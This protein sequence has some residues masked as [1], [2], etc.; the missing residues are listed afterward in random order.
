MRTTTEKTA[1]LTTKEATAKHRTSIG[2][3]RAIAKDGTAPRH[4]KL[5]G[6]VLFPI[7]KEVRHG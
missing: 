7:E 3:L 6:K 4:I 2:K 5:D 1:F